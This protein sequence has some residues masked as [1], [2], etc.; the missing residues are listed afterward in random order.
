[1]INDF[2]LVIET[3]GVAHRPTAS[4]RIIH[5]RSTISNQMEEVMCP[6]CIANAALVAGSVISTGGIGALVAKVVWSKNSGRNDNPKANS[7]K[8]K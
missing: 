5:H 1:L 6:A 2:W 7:G 8:E 4:L 3:V